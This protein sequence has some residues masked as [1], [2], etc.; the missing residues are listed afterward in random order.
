MS[1]KNWKSTDSIL[2]RIIGNRNPAL[3]D[4]L[5]KAWLNFEDSKYAVIETFRDGELVLRVKNS[6]HLQVLSMKR[7][8][9]KTFLNERIERQVKNVKFCLGG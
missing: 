7:E 2:R 1:F 3:K 9:I 6:A 5:E 4:S 8:I